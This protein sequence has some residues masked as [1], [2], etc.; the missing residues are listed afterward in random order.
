MIT[1]SG[2]SGDL[3]RRIANKLAELG[4]P[5][6]FRLASRSPEKLATYHRQGFETAAFDFDDPS[7]MRQAMAGSDS[8]LIISGDSPVEARTVQQRAA[9]VAAEQVGVSHILYTSFTNP[10]AESCFPFA[11]IHGDTEDRIQE[12]GMGFTFLRNPMYAENIALAI[13]HAAAYGLLALPGS[14]GKTTY[15]VK[16]DI[17]ELTAKVLLE[18]PAGQR[19]FDLTNTEAW[20]LAELA[21]LA[22]ERWGRPVTASEMTL[23]D[24]GGMLTGFGLEPFLVEAL[25]GIHSACGAGEYSAVTGDAELL[26][27][28]KPVH[29]ADFLEA[30]TA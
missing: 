1:I 20:T 11:A 23:D 16:D 29:M 14:E 28:R 27:G 25:Q 3:G 8:V 26:L 10:T 5:S 9:I 6:G 17:A 4:D 13:R 18:G 24:F 30:T 22:T 2:A 21:T 15:L 7:S 12:S 19:T